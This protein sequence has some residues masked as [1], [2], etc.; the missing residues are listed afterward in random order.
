MPLKVSGRIVRF[1]V[2]N[3]WESEGCDTFPYT[4]DSHLPTSWA[5]RLSSTAV[6]P[7]CPWTPS[8]NP[9]PVHSGT[10]D[11]LLQVGHEFRASICE[12]GCAVGTARSRFR[13]TV[14]RGVAVSPFSTRPKDP[15][16]YCLARIGVCAGSPAPTLPLG[17]GRLAPSG[18]IADRQLRGLPDLLV[19]HCFDPQAA[20]SLHGWCLRILR[21]FW[22]H[23]FWGACSCSDGQVGSGRL[24][25]PY[26]SAL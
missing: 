16:S 4:A 11:T 9:W 20:G 25:R 5:Q 3:C 22:A 8:E 23:W 13:S 12:L 6:Y 2:A 10:A 17:R 24:V 15:G 21:V 14:M 19:D 18:G 1:R 26:F 7:P